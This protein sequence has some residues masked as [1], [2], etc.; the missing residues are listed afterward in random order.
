MSKFLSIVL[1]VIPLAMGA[2]T[3]VF[4]LATLPYQAD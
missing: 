3:L 2:F 1:R 4:G